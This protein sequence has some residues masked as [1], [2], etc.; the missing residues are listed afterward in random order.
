MHA[1]SRAPRPDPGAVLCTALLNAAR[2]LGLTQT[3]LAR[4]IGLDRSSISRL[5]GRGTL[6]PTCKQGELALIVIRIYRA[7]FA[8]AGGDAP[9]I[10]HWMHGH[11]L[12]L[13]GI[14]AEL[15]GGVQGI[16]AVLNYLDAIRGKI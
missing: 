6:D 7:L 1:S 15:I 2:E 14:P 10:R 5:R 9:A 3:Q 12:H 8:A 16:T 13:N 11:N 4:A